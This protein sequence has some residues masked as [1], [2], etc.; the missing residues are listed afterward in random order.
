M[1]GILNVYKPQG[2][3][4]HAVVNRV[5]R[6]TD[7]R[8]VGHAGTLDPMACGVLPVLIGNAAT[9][10]E[11]IM[12]HDKVY[13]AGVRFGITTD[14]G[15]MTGKVLTEKI[16]EFDD[17]A[18]E[19]VLTRFIGD[20]EQIPPMYSALQKDGV[21]LYDLARQGVTVE[22][23]PRKITIADIRVLSPFDGKRAE[24]EVI[25]SRGTYIRTLA[26]DIGEAL[27]C[28]ACL[29]FLERT[30]C[31]DYHVE[32]AVKIEDLERFYQENTPEKIEERLISPETLFT[33]LP[34]VTLSAFYEKL[35][36]CG[37]EIYLKRARIRA[38]LSVAQPLCRIYGEGG[39]FIGVA[40][41]GTYEN[42]EAVKLKYR[43]V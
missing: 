10:Q 34:S 13:R 23:K 4:S 21:R 2:L 1:N 40:A 15:D 31:G 36:L 26:E 6:F 16:P 17:A 7:T 9:I 37:A 24:I 29:D 14:T 22:R 42:G 28:G 30:V 20:I 43:F 8:R 5:R 39:R 32:D 41:L 27:G 18:L 25:C 19:N 33:H 3:S 12:D 11:L 38:P 35:A